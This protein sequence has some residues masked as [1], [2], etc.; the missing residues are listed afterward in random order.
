[1]KSTRKYA[2]LAAMAFMAALPAWAQNIAVNSR[3]FRDGNAWVEEITGAATSPGMLRI[4]TELGNINVQGGPGG[5]QKDITY[6]VRK[7]VYSGSE[8]AARRDLAKFRVSALRRSDAVVLEGHAEGHSRRMSVEYQV[9]VPREIQVK[10]ST[11]G[12]SIAVRNIAGRVDAESGGGSI[13]LGDVAGPISAETGGGSIEVANSSNLLDLRTGGG[14]IRIT[15]SKGKVKASTGGGSISLQGASDIV[16][17]D[18]G[19]GSVKV[20]QC[21][22]ELHVSTG[23]GSINVGD[24]S[25][26][27]RLETGGGSIRLASAR[28]PVTAETGG[29]SIEL[30]KLMEGA[31]AETGA[32]PITAEFLGVK[33]DSS[34]Q[35]SVGDVIVYLGPQAKVTIK[36]T[37]DMANGHQIRSEFPD[38]KISSEGGN[39][40]PK[41]YYAQGAL[42]G[43]GPVLRVRT[44]SGNIEFRRAK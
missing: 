3:I 13:S 43:G 23:G 25:G 6:T 27:A 19:G 34:L 24:V 10:I 5:A 20:E 16:A 33:T 14:S 31:K 40:G 21:G 36:A 11:E 30:Y 38:L 44:M 32:G 37:L 2:L 9:Q 17:L 29:G 1:M 18:T 15:G 42:N 35:T 28:G 26:L 4:D 8:E 22:S 7:R 39:Y 12:G 41:N